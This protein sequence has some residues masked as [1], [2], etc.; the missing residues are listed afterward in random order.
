MS[1]PL[2]VD[3][4]VRRTYAPMLDYSAD[5]M[6]LQQEHILDLQRVQA[7]Q[8]RQQPASQCR[9]CGSSEY[10]RHNGRHVCA[11]CRSLA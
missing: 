10:L 6:R 11:Y 5:L 7:L 8:I 3:R 1:V 4:K 9:G 2:I